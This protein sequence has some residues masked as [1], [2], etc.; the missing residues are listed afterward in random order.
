MKHL[1][2]LS[3]ILLA[4]G[5]QTRDSQHLKDQPSEFNAS[6][7]S[8]FLDT[9]QQ[10]VV[11]IDVRTL[12]ELSRTPKLSSALH[13]DGSDPAFPE[14]A[15]QLDP[16]KTYVLYCVAGLRSGQAAQYMR[17]ELGFEH[18]YSFTESVDALR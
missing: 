14:K 13:L 6:G 15:R 11:F 7:L 17:K 8:A 1:L 5:C 2:T 10:D 4:L 9:T 12:R 16:S 3:I 18:V